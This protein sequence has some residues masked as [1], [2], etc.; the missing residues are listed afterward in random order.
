MALL[1]WMILLANLS[2]KRD[3]H[4]FSREC[5]HYHAH[6]S[7]TKE[8]ERP[9]EAKIFR[10]SEKPASLRGMMASLVRLLHL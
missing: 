7:G 1:Q 6:F 9:E 4:S 10:F 3:T 5:N 8:E 2:R